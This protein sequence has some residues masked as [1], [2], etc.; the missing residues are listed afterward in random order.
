MKAD[1]TRAAS[2]VGLKDSV[3]F[4]QAA[5]VVLKNSK[6]ALTSPPAILR[7]TQL[8][9]TTGGTGQARFSGEPEGQ[10]RQHR[11]GPGEWRYSWRS[12]AWM[13]LKRV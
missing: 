3:T 9:G 13:E 8:R 2:E 10:A 1:S 12:P 4:W 6:L 11:T 7:Q 5:V